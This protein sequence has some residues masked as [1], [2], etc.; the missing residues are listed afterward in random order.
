MIPLLR[1]QK[2]CNTI[3]NSAGTK[4]LKAMNKIIFNLEEKINLIW[5]QLRYFLSDLKGGRFSFL[6]NL[7]VLN[8]G[9]KSVN[10]IWNLR[11]V[12]NWITPKIF[13]LSVRCLRLWEMTF[14]IS[15]YKKHARFFTYDDSLIV[16]SR[17][18]PHTQN[19]SPPNFSILNEHPISKFSPYKYYQKKLKENP[20]E[21][22]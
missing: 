15:Y 16:Q 22:A 4:T 3:P 10:N 11:R 6:R 1:S 20:K 19:F 9:I 5:S 21:E 2:P 13:V 18:N 17:P 14:Q 7:E 8:S 12:W